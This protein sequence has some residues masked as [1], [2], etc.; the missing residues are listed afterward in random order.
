MLIIIV[1]LLSV[2]KGQVMVDDGRVRGWVLPAYI[3]SGDTMPVITYPEVIVSGD[4]YFSSDDERITYERIKRRFIK[5]YPYA[6]KAVELF[7]YHA[8]VYDSLSSKR[9]KRRYASTVQQEFMDT[10]FEEMKKLTIPEG[11]VLIKLISYMSGM[12]PYDIIKK[13]RGGVQAFFWQRVASLWS[14]DLKSTID[15]SK[16]EDRYLLYLLEL[17]RQGLL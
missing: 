10:Y 7:K 15:T 2:V 3:Q 6:V 8:S 12:T 13:Y 4:I 14:H 17:K 16:K 1:A 5:V 11:E 9:A